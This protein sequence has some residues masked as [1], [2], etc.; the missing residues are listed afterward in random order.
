VIARGKQ[1][2]QLGGGAI[3]DGETDAKNATVDG[4]TFRLFIALRTLKTIKK[5][6]LIAHGRRAQRKKK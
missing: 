1:K 6:A 4:R 5:K 3:A 2:K